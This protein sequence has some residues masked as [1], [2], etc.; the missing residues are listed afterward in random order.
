MNFEIKKV[1]TKERITSIEAGSFKAAIEE[2]ASSYD[3]TDNEKYVVVCGDSQI[4]FR[5]NLQTSSV[6]KFQL[7]AEEDNF[8]PIFRKNKNDKIYA[9]L[10]NSENSPEITKDI[11]EA[12]KKTRRA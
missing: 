10:F 12:D 9:V 5:Y 4:E 11:A 6:K 1:G 2:F 7:S 3:V 8:F